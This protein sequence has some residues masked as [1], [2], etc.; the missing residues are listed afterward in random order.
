MDK[1]GCFERIVTAYGNKGAD[2]QIFEGVDD[3]AERFCFFRVIKI[4]EVFDILAGIGTR[5]A[6][7]EAV[8]FYGIR[9]DRLVDID[10]MLARLQILRREILQKLIAVIKSDHL[11][12][13]IEKLLGAARQHAVCPGS[14]A[15]GM[16]QGNLEFHA[17]E[18]GNARRQRLEMSMLYAHDTPL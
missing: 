16:Q 8:G 18:P 4:M 1:I 10:E 17:F 14:R 9:G 5:C 15:S 13:A 11:Y 2:L 3:A 6:Q 7:D 12:A